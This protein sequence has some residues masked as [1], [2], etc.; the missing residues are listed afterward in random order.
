MCQIAGMG[1]TSKTP[2]SEIPHVYGTQGHQKVRVWPG[3]GSKKKCSKGQPIP[4]LKAGKGLRG[5]GEV[6]VKEDGPTRRIQHPLQ[7]N[8][9]PRY[10]SKQEEKE[11]GFEELE[12][13]LITKWGGGCIRGGCGDTDFGR[14]TAT[15]EAVGNGEKY[16][17]V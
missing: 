5:T 17:E 6:W 8:K 7:K 15:E 4:P 11:G 1:R 13:F 12:S 2:C 9:G 3:G 14:R 10:L 16:A